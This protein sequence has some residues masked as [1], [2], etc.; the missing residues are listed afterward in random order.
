[1]NKTPHSGII[2]WFVHNPVAANLLVI[3]ILI[4]G[5]VVGFNRPKQAFPP[6]P[7]KL[8]TI[9]VAYNSSSA[10]SVEKGVTIKI[11]EALNGINGI[12]EITSTSTRDYANVMVEKKADYSLTTLMRDIKS[13]VDAIATL[14]ARAERPVISQEEWNE[15]ILYIHLFGDARQETLQT[16]ADSIRRKLLLKPN[17]GKVNYVGRR[18]KEIS[19]EVNEGML[20]AC[21]LTLQDVSQR[22][23]NESVIDSGGELKTDLSTITLRADNQAYGEEQFRSIPLRTTANGAVIT[24]GD[25]ATVRS[26]YEEET[27]LN[28]FQGA[29][30]IGLELMDVGGNDITAASADAMQVVNSVKK[31]GL[32]PQNISIATWND[33]SKYINSRVSLLMSNGLMGMVLIIIVLSLFLN[34]RLALWVSCGIPVSIAGALLLMGENAFNFS[35]NELTSF[36]FIVALGIL[37]DDAIV[38]GENIYTVRGTMD[39]PVAATIVGASE[40][41]TPATFGVLTTV[42]AFLPLAFIKGEFGQIFGQFA[43]VVIICLMF[44]LIESKFILPSHLARTRLTNSGKKSRFSRPLAYA[45]QWVTR[46]LETFKERFYTPGLRRV[47]KAP[48]LTLLSFFCILI[49]LFALMISGRVRTVF[50]PNILGNIITV[51]VDMDQEAGKRLTL[52]NADKVESALYTASAAL[53]KE[54]GLNQPPILNVQTDVTSSTG[55]A[56]TAQL[57]QQQGNNVPTETLVARWQKA[58]GSME[59]T[60]T[61][62]FDA[63]TSTMKNIYIE[64]I[65]AAPDT[66]SAATKKIADKL[67]EYA[68]VYNIRDNLK[69]GQPQFR[70]LIKPDARSLGVTLNDL[71]SQLRGGFQGYEVQRFQQGQDDVKVQVRYPAAERKYFEDLRRARIRTANGSLV[72]LEVV[73][74]IIPGYA[75][76][77]INRSNGGRVANIFASTNK[78]ITSPAEVVENLETNLFPKLR[79]QYP[80]ITFR[81]SGEAQEEA[82]ATGS[83]WSAFMI[84]LIMIYTLIAIPLQSYTKPLIIMAAIPFG[85]IGAIGGHMILGY[86]ISMLSLFGVLALCGVVVNDSLLLVTEYSTQRTN[87]LS[88]DEALIS[89]SCK[90]M[91]SILLTSITTFIGLVPLLLETS[92]Q[93][94]YLIPAAIS[95]AYGI[96]F[97]TAITLLLIPALIRFSHNTH[98]AFTRLWTISSH[99]PNRATHE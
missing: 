62:N 69:T 15:H 32:L 57:N 58:V 63:N 44:S 31:S 98:V 96:L 78:D 87:G 81:L 34:L 90:R 21:G 72:P 4:G 64:I 61:V 51:T 55:F 12:K 9:S 82:E 45:Q 56:V 48:G 11:E 37:V 99:Q 46:S 79:K 19:I 74:D 47:L 86:P 24:L 92:E 29:P 2:A 68:G 42:A 30:S 60:D 97:A 39:D 16:L 5:C 38:I 3:L 85:F 67:G 94:Q 1:M 73:A 43:I 80:E 65:G 27:I 18:T 66:L 36:G 35:I 75:P 13:K 7:P 41:A 95:M 52:Q 84:T 8:V 89:A 26:A 33:Q 54:Y 83:L 22:I 91:R 17:I 76:V 53:Q 6:F 25:V 59:G 49:C 71:V 20:Q 14:P 23:Q 40:V 88:I 50:F 93:A 28:R 10:E 77:E 70:L